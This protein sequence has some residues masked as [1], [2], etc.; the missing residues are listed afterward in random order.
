MRWGPYSTSTVLVPG[1]G[2][3]RWHDTA[4]QPT[5]G[6]GRAPCRDGSGVTAKAATKPP[7]ASPGLLREVVRAMEIGSQLEGSHCK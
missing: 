5:L 1:A 6:A 4:L 7:V 2:P 3:R